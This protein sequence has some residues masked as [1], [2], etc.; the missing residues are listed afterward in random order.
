MPA[1]DAIHGAVRRALE[2]DG[3]SVTD[4]PLRLQVGRRMV[5]VD[6]GAEQLLGAVRGPTK[7]AVEVKSFSGA[8]E[9][10][11]LEHA[12]G[13]FMLYDRAL[14]ATQPDRLLWLA[15]PLRIHRGLLQEALGELLLADG[16][17]R[18]VVI[19]T[20]KEVIDRWIPSTPGATNS[21]ES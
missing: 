1:R 20:Q 4:D 16:S 15:I 7:I 12:L 19:D 10:N 8:S 18:L 21:N 5:Y 3:W 14:R 2:S 13:Q 17:L 9:V 11:D 6:L